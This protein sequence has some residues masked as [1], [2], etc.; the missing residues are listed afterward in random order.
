[1]TTGARVKEFE[2][3]IADLLGLQHTLA[4]SSGTAALHLAY[5]TLNLKTGDEGIA[6]FKADEKSRMIAVQSESK[7]PY[8]GPHG[9]SKDGIDALIF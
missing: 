4:V 1:M 7:L 8:Q 6:R 2:K 9:Y 3:E 5:L